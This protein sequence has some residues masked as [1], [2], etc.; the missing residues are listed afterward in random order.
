MGR[1]DAHEDA[2]P[3][4]CQR[5]SLI[6]AFIHDNRH[7]FRLDILC[8]MLGVAISGYYT[9]RGRPISQHQFHD[10][11]LSLRIKA[12][13]EQYKGRYG[14]PRLHIELAQ[15]GLK[16]SKKRVARLM[17]T[18]GLRAKG[19]RKHVVTTDSNHELAVAENLLQRDF[20]PQQPNQVWAGDI[21][22]IPTKEGWLYLAVVLDLYSRLIVGWSMSDRMP[23]ELPV[24]ALQMAVQRRSPPPGLIHHSD[25]GSQYASGLFQAELQ[26]IGAQASMSRQGN[27]WDN[28]CVES[29]FA[30]LKRELLD[31]EPFES[32]EAARAAIFSY[33]EVFYNR[34]R[35]HSTL[36]LGYLTPHQADCHAQAA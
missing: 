26:Q 23:A 14:A 20:Q 3:L 17:R 11:A 10:A 1:T 30:T 19:K 22:Y 36:G 15:E 28:A 32:R 35:R 2:C 27:C 9:W 18:A 4:L 16:C 29:F 5:K 13:H 21:T 34:Q 8:R 24:A 33:L 7:E 31:S 6:F 25:R 12:L